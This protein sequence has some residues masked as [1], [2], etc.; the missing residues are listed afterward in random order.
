MDAI[1]CDNACETT[2]G[3]VFGCAQVS[4]WD[5]N[6]DRQLRA[7][8]A[9]PVEGRCVFAARQLGVSPSTLCRWMKQDEGLKQDEG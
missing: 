8:A 1:I 5:Q 9:F 6:L 7:L 3:R 4:S 2:E